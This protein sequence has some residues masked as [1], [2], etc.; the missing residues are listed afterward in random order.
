MG[1]REFLE[2]IKQAVA[3]QA[4]KDN[5]NREGM[6]VGVGSGS[7]IIYAVNMMGHINRELGLDLVCIPT[8]Y[9]S[10]HLIIQNKLKL[11]SLTE[12][13]NLDLVIDGVDEIDKHLNAIKGGGGC[14]LQEKIVASNT[15]NFIVILDYRKRSSNYL[16][17]NWKNGVPIEIHP[18]AFKPLMA[19]FLNLGGKP[20]LRQRTDKLGPVITDNSNFIVDVDFG[21]IEDPESLDIKLKAIPGVL[22]TGLFIQ[23]ISTAYIGEESGKITI[24]E[25]KR[26]Y[27][28]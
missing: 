26:N 28:S 10:S 3:E 18:M 27:D 5:I 21:L 4:V 15:N 24:E 25:K 2:Q 6:V 20:T 19:K 23:M 22:E 1:N 14:L 12:Y 7:T 16:G 13:S 8:S 11:G 17:S 9:Q